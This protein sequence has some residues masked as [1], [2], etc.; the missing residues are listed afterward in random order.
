MGSLIVIQVLGQGLAPSGQRPAA[1]LRRPHPPEG[2]P[3]EAGVR[4]SGG[5]VPRNWKSLPE[6][7]STHVCAHPAGRLIRENE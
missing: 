4:L 2:L 5:L 7:A 6:S 3:G 1:N